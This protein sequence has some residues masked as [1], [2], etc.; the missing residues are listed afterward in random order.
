MI[1]NKTNLY[2]KQVR[3]DKLNHA[4][5]HAIA[6]TGYES[7][8]LNKNL[9]PNTFISEKQLYLLPACLS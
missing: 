5:I 9:N 3:Y 1:K 7:D 4:Q 2:P 8:H 6:K